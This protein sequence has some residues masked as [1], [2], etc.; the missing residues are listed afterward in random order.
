MS[1]VFFCISVLRSL[2]IPTHLNSTHDTSTTLS[3]D[4]HVDASGKTLDLAE[5][6]VHCSALSTSTIHKGVFL[7]VPSCLFTGAGIAFP[8][9]SVTKDGEGGHEPQALPKGWASHPLVPKPPPL[10]TL[11]LPGSSSGSSSR[12]GSTMVMVQSAGS[13]AGDWHLLGRWHLFLLPKKHC[14]NGL[15]MY[16]LA[17]LK[18]GKK[19]RGDISPQLR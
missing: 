11:H 3:K 14:L 6:S 17:V 18:R 10:S 2:G 4:K 12:H 13:R 15:S 1:L 9:S 19:R 5:D 7:S 8:T 16:M